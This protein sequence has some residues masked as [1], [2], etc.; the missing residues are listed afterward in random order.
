MRE[1]E[2]IPPDKSILSYERGEQR[3]KERISNLYAD[4]YPNERYVTL[5]AAL[6]EFGLAAYQGYTQANQ[7]VRD[8]PAYLEEYTA[9]CY[10]YWSVFASAIWQHSKTAECDPRPAVT[11]PPRAG[12]SN[13]ALHITHAKEII[14]ETIRATRQRAT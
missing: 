2:Y 14:K 6:C 1:R 5:L 4:G 7:V 12:E 10:G 8:D 11:E 13:T 9:Q 3:A